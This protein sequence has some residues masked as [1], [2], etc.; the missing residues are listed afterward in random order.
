[1]EIV[2]KFKM[3]RFIYT[4]VIVAG[5][6]IAYYP[7]QSPQ[8]YALVRLSYRSW[9]WTV[10]L[11]FFCLYF[12]IFPFF[13]SRKKMTFICPN[14]ELAKEFSKKNTEKK[15]CP[16]CETEMIPVEGFYDKK[17]HSDKL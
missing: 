17:N 12:I 2:M 14:C 10:A 15:I 16:D 9:L 8:G 5:L 4:L 6:A 1:M 7:S 11:N 3:K 13:E